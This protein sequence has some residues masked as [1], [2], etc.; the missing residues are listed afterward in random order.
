MKQKIF[1][2]TLLSITVLLGMIIWNTTT[3]DAKRKPNNI[4]NYSITE[5]GKSIELLTYIDEENGNVVYIT[6][7]S[8]A[9]GPELLG[10]ASQPIS[11]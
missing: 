2:S 7:Y 4:N 11:K 3:T 1:F 8:Y 10:I 6:Y 5:L 9:G